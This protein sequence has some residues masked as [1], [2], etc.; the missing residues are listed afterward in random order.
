MGEMSNLT[1]TMKVKFKMIILKPNKLSPPG[2]YLH[3]LY[4]HSCPAAFGVFLN[5]IAAWL[6]G[7]A[8]QLAVW[9][10]D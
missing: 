5:K 9:L 3:K 6:A 4:G 7:L 1:F 8:G 2:I 10:V